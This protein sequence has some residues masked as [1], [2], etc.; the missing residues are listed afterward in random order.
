M[1]DQ[2]EIAA[3]PRYSDVEKAKARAW[4]KKA[5]D[6]RTR[7]EYDY[8]IECYLTGLAYWPE[9]V[10][11][12]HMPLRSAWTQRQQAGGKKAGMMEA[13]KK[14]TSGKDQKQAMLNAEYLL[15][16]DPGNEGHAEALLKNA[17]KGG[18]VAT[19]RF[20]APVLLDLLKREKKP[21]IGRF[22]T[23]RDAVIEAAE[24]ADAGGD[25]E[26]SVALYEFAVQSLDFLRARMPTDDGI[27]NE[28]RDVSSKLTIARGK[29]TDADSFRES[30]RDADKQKQLHDA[31][32]VKQGE[33]TLDDVIAAA[34]QEAEAHPDL[35][36]KINALAD[37]LCKRERRSEED[38][39][40]RIL[41]AAYERTESYAFKVRADDIRLR[42]LARQTRLLKDKA[43]ESGSDE[44]RQQARLSEME[45][46]SAELDVSRERVAKYPT[47]MRMK[48]RLGV[49][50]FK[51]GEFDEAIPV[52]QQAQN[53]PRSRT[54]CL[55]L[56]ARCFF[57][58]G[59]P[60]QTR[61][62]L[63]DALESHEMPGDEL[64]KEM[65]YWLARACEADGDRAE[66]VNQ[67]G[68]LLRLD[69]NYAHGDARA[70]LEKLK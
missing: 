3:A 43:A 34:R 68:K 66:A 29:Y 47:D 58:K 14:P 15:A 7:R 36:A 44:D 54:R 16:K 57:E 67:Y 24:K 1:A 48:Y 2:Q 62:L 21:N 12:G 4:F 70:R 49:A 25:A 28:Q 61:E 33:Q 31:E 22:K 26:S 9:A 10:E 19:A 20:V 63:K 55:L 59:V 11:E 41:L 23:F 51:A 35:P 13:L 5:E 69:Y 17:A 30:L 53:D 60:G 32:R 42:Q 65:T 27:R 46:R 38:E 52:L 40:I 8:A 18:F 45:E 37:A 64:G 6:C 50:L 39:A 56:M